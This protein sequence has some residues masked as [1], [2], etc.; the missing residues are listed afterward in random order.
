MIRRRV[1]VSGDVQ[2]VFF[3][4]TCRRMADTHQVAGWVRNLPGGE[5]EAVFEG[6][7]ERVQELVDWAHEGPP[8]ATVNTVSVHEE[9]P[10][11]PTGF[12]IRPTPGGF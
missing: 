7:P 1:V 12:E 5:V 8:M 3:R 10:Q 2:G 9:E 4:D 11:G 6:E